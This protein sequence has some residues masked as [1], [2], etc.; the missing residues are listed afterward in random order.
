LK[1]KV[2]VPCIELK[3]H[4]GLI[5]ILLI[6]IYQKEKRNYDSVYCTA[7]LVFI[8]IN[9]ST[10]YGRNALSLQVGKIKG[11]KIRLH[12]TLIIGFLLISWSAAMVFTQH[13]YHEFTTTAYWI[14]GAIIAA[15]LFISVLLHGL[16]HSMVALRYGIKIRQ[17]ILFIFGGVSDIS[18]EPKDY[19]KEAAMVLKEAKPDGLRYLYPYYYY[20]HLWQY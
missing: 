1:R 19:R 5:P 10:G 4:A 18:E 20:Y 9:S 13:H 6:C 2:A 15:M 3:R 7:F 11:I 12:F 17:I 16:A 14:V 8:T